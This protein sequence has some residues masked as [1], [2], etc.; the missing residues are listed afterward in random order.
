MFIWE[1]I[2][3]DFVEVYVFDFVK[4]IFVLD[5]VERFD[6]FAN[7]HFHFLFECDCRT[8]WKLAEEDS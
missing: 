5:V 3:H 6:H 2:V 8:C 7:L 1:K 4:P